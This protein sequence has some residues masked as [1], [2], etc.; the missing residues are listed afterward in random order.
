[1]LPFLVRALVMI[2]VSVAFTYAVVPNEKLP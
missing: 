1:M 2:A